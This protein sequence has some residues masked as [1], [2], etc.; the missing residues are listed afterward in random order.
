MNLRIQKGQKRSQGWDDAMN[1]N[2]S[3]N[4]EWF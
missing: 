3:G 4:T 2:M 1:Q